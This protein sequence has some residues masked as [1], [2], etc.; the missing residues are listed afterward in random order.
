M[1]FSRLGFK[2]KWHENESDAVRDSY[3]ALHYLIIFTLLALN[4]LLSLIRTI[5]TAPGSIPEDDV[6]LSD[7]EDTE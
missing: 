5:N 3:V 4:L 1:D 6:I 2:A 7:E